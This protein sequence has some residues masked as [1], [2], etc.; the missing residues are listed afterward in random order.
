M[1]ITL[2]REKPGA[3]ARAAV[4]AGCD[5][6]L[7]ADESSCPTCGAP[8]PER[9]T[10]ARLFNEARGKLIDL[11]FKLI[12]TLR[13]LLRGPGT[14][15]RR[16][17]EGNRQQISNPIWFA[18]LATTAYIATNNFLTRGAGRVFNPLVS[19]RGLWPYLFFFALVP[20]AAL[21]RLLFRKAGYNFAETYTFALLVCGQLVLA[22]TAYI[23]FATVGW[24]WARIALTLMEALY[25]AWAI[26]GLM[27]DRRKSAWL[28]G[29]AAFIAYAGTAVGVLWL[30][31]AQLLSVFA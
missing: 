9:I 2:T 29:V 13:D 19:A 6:P 27:G 3:V 11:D 17:I 16:Y 26:T 5:Q 4:C 14:A 31:V 21:Q 30:L 8:R 23:P 22:E 24:P 15:A 7:R 12:R 1:P 20:G 28:R 18:F 25:F 10:L